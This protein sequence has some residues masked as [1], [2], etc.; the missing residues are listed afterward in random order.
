MVHFKTLSKRLGS[1]M[2]VI[3]MLL[4][5]A[6]PVFAYEDLSGLDMTE[7]VDVSGGT[8]GNG[9]IV[10]DN[11]QEDPPEESTPEPS[12]TPGSDDGNDSTTPDSSSGEDQDSPATS[13]PEKEEQENEKQDYNPASELSSTDTPGKVSFTASYEGLG[14]RSSSETII[15]MIKDSSIQHM[16]P[17]SGGNMQPAYIFTTADGQA[18]YCIEPARWNSVNGDI[19]TGSQTFS[20]LSQ[21]KQNQIAR[22]I[23]ASGGSASNHAYYMA[24]QAIIWEIAYGQSHGSGSV[25]NAVIAANSSKLSAAYHDI[26]SKMESGGEIPSFMSPDSQS[27]TQHEMTE[28]GGSYSID[29]TNS[30]SSVTLKAGDFKSKAPFKFSV[31]G[32]TLT[33][34]DRKSVV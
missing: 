20:G 22:A 15:Y 14:Y 30:N 21:S 3:V 17:F 32:D 28:T 4:T 33:V 13:T 12:P 29:L 16:Y 23:A 34:T 1:F 10:E 24:C 19:V 9:V 31:S 18:A 5:F 6:S 7:I 11:P 2:L 25:Y 27:P 8:G 26:L